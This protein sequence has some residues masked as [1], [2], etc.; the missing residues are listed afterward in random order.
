[1]VY[2]IMKRSF[3]LVFLVAA[4][5]TMSAQHRA[6]RQHLSDPASTTVVARKFVVRLY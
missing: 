3:V 2:T 5:T 1:M 4:V 6:D